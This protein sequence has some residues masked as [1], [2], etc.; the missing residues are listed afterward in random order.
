MSEPSRIARGER[1][2]E[3]EWKESGG[4]VCVQCGFVR[5]YVRV[6]VRVRVDKYVGVGVGDVGV[7]G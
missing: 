7:D 6:R 3:K 4:G 1:N 5:M 2:C